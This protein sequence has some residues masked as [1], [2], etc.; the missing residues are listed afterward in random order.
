MNEVSPEPQEPR[1]S[2]FSALMS[3]AFWLSVAYLL[4]GVVVTLAK[5]HSAREG[6]HTAAEMLDAVPQ[7][8]LHVTGGWEPLIAAIRTGTIDRVGYRVLMMSLTV[9]VIF[10][11]ALILSAILGMLKSILTRAPRRV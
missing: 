6:W 9:G 2:A 11:Q 4:I 1:E 10:G 8:V 7:G 5:H 3:Q